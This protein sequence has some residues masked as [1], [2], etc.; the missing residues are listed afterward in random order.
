MSY[1]K[2][3]NTGE[4][5][6]RYVQ[7]EKRQEE[8][9]TVQTA[10]DGTEYLTRFGDPVISYNLTFYVKKSGRDK[11]LAAFDELTLLEISGREGTYQGRL[12]ELSEFTV[13]TNEWYEGSGVVAALSEVSER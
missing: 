2:I 4:V 6:T 13:L 8:T 3:K 11:L 10:L 1:I 12:K 5:I 9:L 7:S